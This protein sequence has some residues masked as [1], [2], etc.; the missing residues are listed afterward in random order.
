MISSKICSLVLYKQ[1]YRDEYREDLPENLYSS[2][3]YFDGF[4]IRTA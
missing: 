4:A 2:L 3:G 1:H